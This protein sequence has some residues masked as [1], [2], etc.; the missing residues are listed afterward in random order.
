MALRVKHKALIQ[1]SSDTA[2]KSKRY[3]LEDDSSHEVDTEQ[4][5]AEISGDLSIADA[6]TE[7][8]SFGDVQDAR[9]LYLEVSGL[10]DVTING[11]NVPMA[12]QPAA[13]TTANAK[14]LIDATI[15]SVSIT[16]NSGGTLTGSYAL[17]G[18]P[19]P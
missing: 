9:G 5:Q 8:L 7:V 4:Y 17:W 14:F 19:L 1:I 11:A 10:C 12:M 16:N 18:N 6:A 13:G 15:T 2:Q 3:F